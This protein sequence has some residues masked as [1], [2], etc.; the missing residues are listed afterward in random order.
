MPLTVITPPSVPLCDGEL[1]VNNGSFSCTVSGSGLRLS[2][3]V[4]ELARCGNIVDHITGIVAVSICG[5]WVR[6]A[7]GSWHI[8]QS[9]QNIHSCHTLESWVHDWQLVLAL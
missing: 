4:G 9:W 6:R 5:H 1:P 7:G 2:P 3:D 8:L